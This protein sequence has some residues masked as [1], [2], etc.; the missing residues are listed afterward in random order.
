MRE[1]DELTLRQLADKVRPELQARI[2]ELARRLA[3]GG[4][5][6]AGEYI[7]PNPTRS[8]QH[9]GSFKIRM[10]GA[11]TGSFV[12][13]AGVNAP[14]RNGGD[15]GDVID[16]IAYTQTDRNRAK[17]IAWALDWCGRSGETTQAVRLA[18]ARRAVAQTQEQSDQ[19]RRDRARRIWRR[20]EPRIL[21]TVAE[22][23]LR[24]ARGIPLEEITSLTRD[25]RFAQDLKH[26]RSGLYFPAIVALL[27]D[28]DG[29]GTGVHCTFLE[30][31]GS[32]KACVTPPKMMLGTASGSVI[33]VANGDTGLG[34]ELAA[35]AGKSGLLI[36][37]EG[38]EDAL[39][40]AAVEPGARVWAVGSLGNFGHAP[41]D[42]P[43][44]SR[45]IL[46]ADN[47]DGQPRA[48][49][50]LQHGLAQL[51]EHGKQVLVVHSP[52]GKDFNDALRGAA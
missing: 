38:L 6:A 12:D 1:R 25:M 9:I 46:A 24:E 48:V 41:I 34:P 47:D 32:A 30:L 18:V 36:L 43:C 10:H 40:L 33:R 42:H 23:Y 27:R 51:R 49:A 52:I 26:W 39:T 14:F 35:A 8:D 13:Y 17:A 31:D 22:T 19:A 7:A 45:V 29:N 16:L 50:A 28:R 3:P 4:Y 37:A 11:K 21:G 5:E 20:A 44:V 15:R 2:S